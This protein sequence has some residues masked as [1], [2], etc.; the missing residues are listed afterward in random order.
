MRMYKQLSEIKPTTQ[1]MG[2]E[3]KI[4]YLT[5]DPNEAQEIRKMLIRAHHMDFGSVLLMYAPESEVNLVE[6]DKKNIN[7]GK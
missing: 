7:K 3:L 1:G 6:D 4:T 2:Y 5:N